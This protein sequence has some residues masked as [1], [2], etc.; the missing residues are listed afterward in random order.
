MVDNS[1]DQ[2]ALNMNLS[3]SKRLARIL[4]ASVIVIFLLGGLHLISGCGFIIFLDKGYHGTIIDADTKEPIQGVV[5]AAI[6]SAGCLA[7]AHGYSKRLGARETVTDANGSFRTPVFFTINSLNC[8]RGVTAFAVFKGGYGDHHN[9]Y[10]RS[11]PGSILL[12]FDYYIYASDLPDTD[13]LFRKGVVIE[14][15]KLKAAHERQEARPDVPWGIEKDM[16][17]LR[18]A[19]DTETEYL[20]GL[21]Y[22]LRVWQQSHLPTPAPATPNSP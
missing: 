10:L 12:N 18:K 19:L 14:L 8:F 2:I 5:V 22:P 3:D 11:L 17:E 7:P 6:Y 13:D 21:L 15:P 9:P 16:P 4:R 20:E 1:P